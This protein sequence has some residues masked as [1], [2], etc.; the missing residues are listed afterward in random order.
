MSMWLGITLDGIPEALMLGFMTN[1]GSLSWVLLVSVFIANFPEAFS[2]A[3]LLKGHGLSMAKIMLM[4]TM[5]FV[6]TGLLAMVGSLILPDDVKAD[7]LLDRERSLATSTLEGLTGGAMMAMTATAMLPEAFHGAGQA[8][9]LL[10]VS[11]FLV[12]V[13]LN[14]IGAR[15]GKP[16]DLT[17]L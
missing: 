7:S 15:V 17:Q 8:S 2:A 4:W 16:Q 12:S 11:G 5:V 10:F 9:G 3:S 13:I 6:N 1:D 14:G